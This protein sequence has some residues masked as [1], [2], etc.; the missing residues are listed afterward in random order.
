MIHVSSNTNLNDN[1]VYDVLDNYNREYFIQSSAYTKSSW[2]F[3][4]QRFLDEKNEC[5]DKIIIEFLDKK[6]LF[7]FLGAMI[8][9]DDFSTLQSYGRPCILIENKKILTN[10]LSKLFTKKIEQEI[11]CYGSGVWYRDFVINGE[12]S[13]L[14][15][16]LLS[17]G[18]KTYPV[19]SNVIDL[20][21][22]ESKIRTKIRKSYR[23]LINWGTQNFSFQ[24]LTAAEIAW[25][26][27]NEFRELHI[28]ESGR[29]T[30]T[31]E[32]WYRQ[33]EMVQAKEAFIILARW[34]NQL[35]SAG[36]FNHSP[37]NCYYGSSASRRDM[38]D[39]PLFH[40]LMWT[41]ILHAKKI[42]CRWFEIGE[43]VYPNHPADYPPSSKELGISEFKAGFGG[44]TRMFLDL[45]WSPHE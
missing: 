36:F 31:K 19:F 6:F 43:Q 41:A 22:D 33:L 27:M 14:S 23:S 17:K 37:T 8:K 9:K 26:H 30:R 45:K 42:G 3:R 13:T 20:T 2:S 32:T 39:K 28:R 18:A 11:S 44:V 16:Y 25:E 29:E 10:N 4:K 15:R 24:L 7:L 21:Q 34:K 5:D 1:S 35:V 40:S 12:L 38:F